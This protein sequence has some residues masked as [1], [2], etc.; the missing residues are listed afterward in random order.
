MSDKT[1]TTLDMAEAII[2]ETNISS[3]G[4]RSVSKR[5]IAHETDSERICEKTHSFTLA[6][7]VKY[8]PITP[9]IATHKSTGDKILIPK[10]QFAF[11][12]RVLE[13]YSAEKNITAEDIKAVIIQTDKHFLIRNSKTEDNKFDFDTAV[14]ELF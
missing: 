8:P 4:N 9:D 13:T 3:G 6:K 5:V 1:L 14:D 10:T 11:P 2:T 7:A 12:V